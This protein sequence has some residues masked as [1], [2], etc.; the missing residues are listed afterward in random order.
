M[1]CARL[2]L[3]LA[4]LMALAFN[5]LA[6]AADKVRV[7]AQRTGTLAWE[8]DVVR[9]HGLDRKADLALEVVMLASPLAQ[10]V[11]LNGA[12]ADVIVADWIWVARERALGGK[13]LF[14][15]YSSAVGALMVPPGSKLKTLADLKDRKIGVGGGAIDKSWLLVRALAARQ[16]VVLTRDSA[17]SYGAPPLIGEKMRQRE[18][19]AAL[20][21]WN[22]SATLRA[23]GYATLMD[24]TEVEKALG[25]KDAVAMLGYV[26]EESWAQADRGRVD[27]F[28]SVMKQAKAIL[29]RS[30]DE[31]LRIA[32]LVQAGDG[33]ALEALRDSYR[34]GIPK[35][36]IA[37]EV[38]D[39][40]T[41]FKVLVESGGAE[42]AGPARRLDPQMFHQPQD[43][44]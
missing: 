13:L 40:Q 2:R 5:S 8:L 6:V 38:E 14:Y 15:P 32:P 4:A 25:A 22:F 34:A 9:H 23:E 3:V 43:G 18:F 44:S 12:T 35:R 7:V 29:A 37:A 39:A 11:A 10:K 31:W 17:V 24:M 20:N 26:F 30:D 21:Y 42:L 27:R 28:L 33:R 1:R 36:T 19:D 16:G 41:L